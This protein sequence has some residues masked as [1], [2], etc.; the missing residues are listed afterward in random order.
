M[1]FS[2]SN[3]GSEWS[4]HFGPDSVP[5]IVKDIVQEVTQKS[6]ENPLAAWSSLVSQRQD[7]LNNH[8]ARVQITPNQERSMDMRGEVFSNVAAQDRDTIGHQVSDL[9]DCEFYWE[10]DLLDLDAVFRPGNHTFSHR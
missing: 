3:D 2:V 10:N 7:F 1:I 9:D 4:L 6:Q 5:L 8:L